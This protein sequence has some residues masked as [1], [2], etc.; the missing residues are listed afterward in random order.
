MKIF[1]NIYDWI[2]LNFLK[3][4]LKNTKGRIATYRKIQAV[5]EDSAWQ[6]HRFFI[7]VN[8]PKIQRKI[9]LHILEEEGHAQIFKTGVVAESQL[10]F[11]PIT[12]KRV[13]IEDKDAEIWKYYAHLYAGELDAAAF[14]RLLS[15]STKKHD[16]GEDVSRVLEEEMKHVQDTLKAPKFLDVS[17]ED[18][19]NYINGIIKSRSF[20]KWISTFQVIVNW[21]IDKLL[22]ISYLMLAPIF[23][24]QARKRIKLNKHVYNN[25]TL[26]EY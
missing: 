7:R 12:S 16:L 4:S 6:L 23:F 26:K 11:I 13:E 14:F 25:N 10:P 18:Y 24:I 2:H 17:E 15:K 1:N 22:G 20:D 3:F 9:F 19:K 21:V 8:D 5:E